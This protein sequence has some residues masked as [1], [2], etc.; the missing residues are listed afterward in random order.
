VTPL[1]T[2]PA[3]GLLVYAGLHDIAARTI[4]NWVSVALFGLG[5]VA[6]LLT[7]TFWNGLAATGITF[8][9]L[10]LIWMVGIF[11]GGD[12]KIWAAMTML[13]PPHWQNELAFP[14]DTMLC[15]GMLSLLYLVLKYLMPRP[16]FWRPAWFLA[17]VWRAECWR[18]RQKAALPY[19]CAIA[20]AGIINLLHRS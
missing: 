2:L 4:P 10:Y 20:A 3:I 6:Q 16:T 14:L 7:H 11:G 17:R 8:A 18:I 13:I 9:L 5:V 1:L 15:G 12:A 19:A